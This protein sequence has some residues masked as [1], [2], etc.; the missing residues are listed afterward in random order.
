M[1]RWEIGQR[2]RYVGKNRPG[3]RV[4]ME[5][6]D[7]GATGTI[8]KVFEFDYPYIIELD[9]PRTV[10]PGRDMERVD[11]WVRVSGYGWEAIPDV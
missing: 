9:E 7:V 3:G 1:S 8:S 5:E 2:V 4:F 10:H 11:T 6:T